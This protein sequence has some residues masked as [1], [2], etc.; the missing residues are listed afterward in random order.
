MLP[1]PP[2]RYRTTIITN[3]GQPGDA[4]VERVLEAGATTIVERPLG[5]EFPDGVYSLSHV[6][7][8]FPMNDSLYGLEPDTDEFGVNLGAMAIRGE[9]GILVVSLDSLV[10]VSSNPV[11]P[12]LLGRIEEGIAADAPAASAPATDA[13]DQRRGAPDGVTDTGSTR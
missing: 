7:L 12:Y 3:A 8:P 2:R 13:A 6:A 4:V 5:L 10:R 1:A 11:Y 9:R